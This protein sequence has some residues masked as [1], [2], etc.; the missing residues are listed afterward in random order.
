MQEHSL[1]KDVYVRSMSTRGHLGGL[2]RATSDAVRAIDASGKD[3]VIVETV[4]AGQSEVQ[5]VEVAHTVIVADVPGA[6]GLI[7]RSLRS[8]QCSISILES[9]VGDPR[10][11]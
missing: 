10:Y 6:G 8:M 7:R 11:C 4:G 2:A 9:E 3:I 1:D 5:V